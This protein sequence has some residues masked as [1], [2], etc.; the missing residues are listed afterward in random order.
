MLVF[1]A[2]LAGPTTDSET[3]ARAAAARA[4]LH[5]CGAVGEQL[6][7]QPDRAWAV[8]PPAAADHAALRSALHEPMPQGKPRIMIYAAGGHLATDEYSIALERQPD[9]TWTGTAVGRGKIWVQDAPFYPIPRKQWTL[10]QDK[11]QRLDRIVQDPCFYAEPTEFL[12]DMKEPPPLGMM[13]VRLEVTTSTA[14]RN[15]VFLGRDVK[16][17]TAELVDLASPK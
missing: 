10:A 1:A 7:A 8:S 11:A 13:V 12:G 15:T 16:G 17:L 5:R 9:S 4:V 3:V 2:A 14:S 6:A